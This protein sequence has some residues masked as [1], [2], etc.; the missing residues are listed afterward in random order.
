MAAAGLVA[1]QIRR[2]TGL[3][4]K[5]LEVVLADTTNG[6]WSAADL[7]LMKEIGHAGK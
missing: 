2:A 4:A 6:L 1:W 7:K 3:G 5:R